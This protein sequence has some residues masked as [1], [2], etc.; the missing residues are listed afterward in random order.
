MKG[1]LGIAAPFLIGACALEWHV[2]LNVFGG[3][4]WRGTVQE[5]PD[6]VLKKSGQDHAQ[7]VIV[8]LNW[9]DSKGHGSTLK[10]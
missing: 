7:S 6:F 3:A 2:L 5:K 4:D 8:V 9:I 1:R 10:I